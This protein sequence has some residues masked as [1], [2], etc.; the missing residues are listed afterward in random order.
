MSTTITRRAI[1]AGAP[2]I[3][4]TMAL[5]VSAALADDSGIFGVIDEWRR[6]GAAY[7]QALNAREAAE[8]TGQDS[9]PLQHEE[10]RLLGI[11][12][13]LFD[14]IMNTRVTS[15]A[16]ML[17]KID[18]YDGEPLTDDTVASVYDDLQALVGDVS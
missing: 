9:D 14:R 17:A 6:V 8:R 10:D 12:R 11:E 15:P 1:L 13:E 3:A 18:M 16:A 4:A 2:G 5:P 7:C